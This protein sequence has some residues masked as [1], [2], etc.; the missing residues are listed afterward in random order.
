MR[1]YRYFFSNPALPSTP[2]STGELDI[3]AMRD[4]AARFLG[5]HDFRN[6]CKLDASKQIENFSRHIFRAEIEEPSMERRSSGTK[7]VT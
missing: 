2:N 4:A 7:S 6:F 1:H 3:P 5:T